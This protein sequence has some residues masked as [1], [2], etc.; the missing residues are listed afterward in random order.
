MLTFESAYEFT[1]TI[2]SHTSFEKEE[3]ESYFDVLMDLPAGS[4]IIEVGLEYGRSSSIALQVAAE[5]HHRY[6]GIDPFECHDDVYEAWTKMK[7][8]VG[9]GTLY[10]MHSHAFPMYG[11]IDAILIDGDHSHEGVTADCEHF[12]E[13]VAIGG[14]ALF[15]DYL[16]ES[17][18][19]VTQAVDHYMSGRD[20]WCHLR[21]A[22][23][24]A[25][26]ERL[27]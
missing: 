22:G 5:R 24:L 4:R 10:R 16:R 13:H 6:I 17:L 7:E 25:V 26:W 21:R 15:H 27:P 14:Y 23:T 8:Q 20:E 1:K 18:P 12:L 9:T 3:C 19:E 2:G 11:T